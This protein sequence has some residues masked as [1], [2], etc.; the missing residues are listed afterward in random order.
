MGGGGRGVAASAAAAAAAAVAAAMAAKA[1]FASDGGGGGV[2]S[3]EEARNRYRCE[4]CGKGFITPSKLQRHSFSH[5]EGEDRV[6]VLVNLV[7]P[8][9][10]AKT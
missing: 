5:R 7:R 4:E 6:R 8:P 2:L 9:F 10:W 1:Q 3:K